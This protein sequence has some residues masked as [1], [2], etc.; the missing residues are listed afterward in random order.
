MRNVSQLIAS[1]SFT[2]CALPLCLLACCGALIAAERTAADTP[3][4]APKAAKTKPAANALEL[5]REVD[6]LIDADVAKSDVKAAPVINDEDFL[7]RQCST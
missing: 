5:A 2:R 6:Q 1:R 3:K 7:R 4:A